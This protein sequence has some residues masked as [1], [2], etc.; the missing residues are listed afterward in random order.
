M[1]D[2]KTPLL[3][4]ATP[5]EKQESAIVGC[6]IVLA[7]YLGAFIGVPVFVCAVVYYIELWLHH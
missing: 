2:P 7:F 5:K 3:D 4:Y 6:L 1:E